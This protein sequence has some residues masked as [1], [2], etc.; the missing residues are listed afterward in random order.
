M[1]EPFAVVEKFLAAY[2]EADKQLI[3]AQD[4]QHFIQLCQRRGQKPV[5]FVPALDGSFE[6]FFKKDSLWQSEDLAAVV[7][8]DVGR[9]CILQGPMA[10][11]YSTKVDEPIKEILDG[12]HEGHIKY[13]L[14]DIYG[15]DES[16]IPVVEYFGGKL[17]EASDEIDV[18]GLTV[19]ELNNKIIYRLSASPSAA[20]PKPDS[21]MS[22]LAGKSYS[23]RHAFFTAD[24]FVQGQRFY[25]N[26][27][28][29]IFEPAPG[30]MVEVNYPNDP[31]KTVIT[32]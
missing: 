28:Q 4:V 8:E 32:V 31:S 19:S 11:K 10:V 30:M 1:N 23:W 26:P 3:N 5:P 7:G 22:L 14:Q 18:E 24:V 12:V 13:L 2:P 16:K 15:G 29:R 27:M 6:F 9:T 25:T 17:L 21:W 20:L